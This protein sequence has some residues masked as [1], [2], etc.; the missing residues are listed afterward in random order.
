M[1]SSKNIG[2]VIVLGIIIL[3][4]VI[5]GYFLMDYMTKE[6]EVKEKKTEVNDL[7]INTS[8][9]YIYFENTEEIEEEIYKEDVVLNFKGLEDVNSALYNELE[10]LSENQVLYTDQEVP[11][12]IV[13]SLY[14]FSY[15]EYTKT[16]YKDLVSV[17]ISDYDYTCGTSAVPKGTKSYVI[18]ITSGKI[19]SNE[20]LLNKFEITDDVI[21]ESVKKRLE[22]TQTLDE[23]EQVIDIDGTL[24]NLK[25]SEYGQ[26]KAL[27]ISK[28]GKLVI[29]FLVKSNKIN[30]ND[31]IELN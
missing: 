29:N 25:N 7:R 23:E 28:N 12:G 15:R 31:S 4:F 17:V 10:T 24:E 9:D 6:T 27:S 11:E 1:D 13:C 3:T 18:D 30:Y 19:L 21:N 20:E 22:D 8:K 5:G 2:G 16:E 26:E 14:S